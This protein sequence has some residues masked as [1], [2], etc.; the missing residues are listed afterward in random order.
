MPSAYECEMGVLC[1]SCT[2]LN[3]TNFDATA[4]GGNYVQE[5]SHAV[6]LRNVALES[7]LWHDL[8]QVTSS[9]LLQTHFALLGHITG[10]RGNSYLCTDIAG[11]NQLQRVI[12]STTENN[13]SQWARSDRQLGAVC[14][15]LT[16]LHRT[17]TAMQS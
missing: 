3:W 8:Q 17:V 12:R 5:M 14:C 11:R 10:A 1:D 2:S 7:W 15:L 4:V 16:W 6:V 13:T 9:D